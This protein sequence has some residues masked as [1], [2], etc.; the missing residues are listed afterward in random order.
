MQSTTDTEAPQMLRLTQDSFTKISVHL[1]ILRV[2]RPFS[3]VTITFQKIVIKPQNVF[4]V[5]LPHCLLD[6]S[7][8]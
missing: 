1:L 3:E 6:N 7:A 5:N 8:Q 2:Q 4:S